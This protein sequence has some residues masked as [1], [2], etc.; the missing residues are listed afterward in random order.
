MGSLNAKTG[1]VRGAAHQ[2]QQGLW[3]GTVRSAA[4]PLICQLGSAYVL[5]A[6]LHGEGIYRALAFQIQPLWTLVNGWG[7]LLLDGKKQRPSISRHLPL[8]HASPRYHKL[9]CISV[10]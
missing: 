4:A 1:V 6:F 7:K 10:T 2:L 9:P 8:P 5:A 3:L